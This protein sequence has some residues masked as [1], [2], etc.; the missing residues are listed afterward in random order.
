M[1]RFIITALLLLGAFGLTQAQTIKQVEYNALN[2]DVLLYKK[3]KTVAS[4][5]LRQALA[6][7]TL[8]GEASFQNYTFRKAGKFKDRIEIIQNNDKGEVA[9]HLEIL[10]STFLHFLNAKEVAQEEQE[11]RLATQFP[12]LTFAIE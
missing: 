11:K 5:S 7:M 9:F 2:T 1:S 4:S 8:R 3:F 10:E 6:E 12:L